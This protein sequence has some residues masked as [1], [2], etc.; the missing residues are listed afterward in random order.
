[1]PCGSAPAIRSPSVRW[2]SADAASGRVFAGIRRRRQTDTKPFGPGAVRRMEAAPNGRH[3]RGRTDDTPQRPP[4]GIA[5]AISET[6]QE[7]GRN[8]TDPRQFPLK[9][10]GRSPVSIRQKHDETPTESRQEC[11]RGAATSVPT[12]TETSGAKALPATGRPPESPPGARAGRSSARHHPNSGAPERSGKPAAGAARSPTGKT[13]PPHETLP[14]PDR[15]I[16][17]ADR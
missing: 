3:C 6:R 14:N 10:P 13:G 16:A 4:S 17:S 8:P 5:P 1:M 2:R 11:G 15:K 7:P 9:R 12:A